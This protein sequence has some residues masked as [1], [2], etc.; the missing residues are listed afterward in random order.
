MASV[1]KSGKLRSIKRQTAGTPVKQDAEFQ[2]RLAEQLNIIKDELLKGIAQGMQL[3]ANR[4]SAAGKIDK[5]AVDPMIAELLAGVQ[6]GMTDEIKKLIKESNKT[7]D[8][9][10]DKFGDRVEGALE[11]LQDLGAEATSKST[12][13]KTGDI[14]KGRQ[15][16]LM[17]MDYEKPGTTWKDR[18][19]TFAKGTAMTAVGMGDKFWQDEEKQ[20]KQDMYVESQKQLR[21]GS[22][23][24][25]LKAEYKT[26]EEYKQNLEVSN[27]QYQDLKASGDYSP[28]ELEKLDIA[29]ERKMW[30]DFVEPDQRP[31][32]STSTPPSTAP[33]SPAPGAPGPAMAPATPGTPT[34]PAT[35]GPADAPQGTSTDEKVGSILSNKQPQLMSMEYEKPGTTWKDRLKTFAKGTAMTAVGMGD[36]FWAGQEKERKQDMYVE[37]QKQLRPDMSADDLKKEYQKREE[38]KQNL[39]V[40]DA[41]YQDLKASG[42][43]TPEELEKLDIAKERKMWADFVRPDEQPS[44]AP[45]TQAAQAGS[46]ATPLTSTNQSIVVAG[47][48]AATPA[49]QAVKAVAPAAT[50][51][52]VATQAIAPAATTLPAVLAASVA[53]GAANVPGSAAI[54]NTAAPVI[55]LDNPDKQLSK[56]VTANEE[57]AAEASK[58]QSALLGEENEQTDVYKE[59]VEQTKE[60]TKVLI[61]IRDLLKEGAAAGGGQGGE[62]GGGLL[63]T[64]MD[65]AGAAPGLLGRAGKALG[66]GA[67][68]VGGAVSKGAGAL[69][70]FATSAGGMNALKIGG[71]ALAVG[72]GAYTAYK[73][74]GEAEDERAAAAADIEKRV[75]S[76]Q[77][78]KE[79]GAAQLKAVEEGATE[80]KGGAVGEGTGMAAGGL[81]GMKAGAMLGSFLGP[82]GTV[83]GGA[84]GGAAGAFLGSKAGKTVGEYAGKGVN[85]L[86]NAVG[87]GTPE[88]KVPEAAAAG[89]AGATPAGAVSPTEVK[90][91]QGRTRLEVE[92]LYKDGKITKEEYTTSIRE[93]SSAIT[94]NTQSPQAAGAV[95]AATPATA[96]ATLSTAPGAGQQVVVAGPPAS[97]PGAVAPAGGAPAASPT[98]WTDRLKSA[99]GAAVP[100]LGVAGAAGSALMNTDAG[101]AIGAKVGEGASWLR[102]KISAGASFVGDNIGKAIPAVGLVQQA[103]SALMN[104]DA[105]KAIGAKVGEGASWLKNAVG[106]G[107]TTISDTFNRGVSGTAAFQNVDDEVTRRAKKA[108][109]IDEAGNV[110]DMEKYTELRKQVKGEVMA[111]D[112]TA[113]RLADQKVASITDL[114]Q[115]DGPTGSTSLMKK[116]IVAQK[117]ILGSTT[118]GSLFSAKGLE[119]GTFMGAKS[120]ESTSPT[121]QPSTSYS[122]L[123]GKRTS[124]GLLGRD[125]FEVTDAQG[126]QK[127]VSK[128]DYTKMQ[129][130]VSKGDVDGAQKILAEAKAPES[131]LDT[132]KRAVGKASPVLGLA[133][134]AGS[135]LMG[136]DIGKTAA[137]KIGEGAGW[138]KDKLSAG[139]SF[140][141]D[142][143][144]KAIPAVGLAQKA[145]SALMNTDMGKSIV[146]AFDNA[147]K[148][149][150]AA[151]LDKTMSSPTAPPAALNQPLPDQTSVDAAAAMAKNISITAPPPT[152]IPAPASQPQMMPQPFSQNIRNSENTIGNYIRERYV[153]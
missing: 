94:Q 141:G 31:T 116:G 125:T 24:A 72:A 48:P 122:N 4:M 140:V 75:E 13:E 80:K 54:P 136:T 119:T 117:S 42:D 40:A 102:D 124:G 22:S 127:K 47:P 12:D 10:I 59:Q 18:V 93:I 110:K 149:K 27:A 90:D 84:L 64:A 32:E 88:T 138:L 37:S 34:Q 73:G 126:V 57:S 19:K 55:N 112:P 103:G 107:I 98:S 43:Y 132:L 108:G 28:A 26:R 77:I 118:L 148:T 121:G 134:A 105:G 30:A 7:L 52:P 114:K 144:G 39:E 145:G 104:T 8:K 131:M 20:R 41:Q 79:E 91:K 85:W 21:P 63:D 96:P 99:I 16:K 81:A 71:A 35:L 38:Y 5:P 15:S 67:K 14:L 152:V 97:S 150:S 23:E 115:T 142:N 6:E 33:A 78:S 111:A 130:L 95:P 113:N 109:V 76:G 2:K 100:A 147:D 46:P 69:G 146:G 89:A 56:S 74:Y 53:P 45:A 51:I 106:S 3:E 58:M 1:R 143:I 129:D 36:A 82:A 44:A 123:L 61:E 137:T 49:T 87:M 92:K 11:P 128:D 68:A 133:G 153:G 70:R 65:V 83:V 135:A 17:S 101:K 25:D 50:A 66:R 120:D 60:Q 151:V 139:A 86:K 62:G 29:K 9:A